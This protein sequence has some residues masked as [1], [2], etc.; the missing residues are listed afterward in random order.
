MYTDGIWTGA[1]WSVFAEHQRVTDTPTVPEHTTFTAL[2]VT[3]L[4][5][6]HENALADQL[7]VRVDGHA[8]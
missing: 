8:R 3:K 5:A 1:D 2:V 6:V 7:V 4:N